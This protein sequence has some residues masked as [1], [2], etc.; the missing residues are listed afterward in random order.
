M[1][2]REL[3]SVLEKFAAPELQEDYD[4]AGLITG[5]ATWE[6]TG[7]LCTLDVTEDVI[8]E[9]KEKNCNLVVAHH[10]IIFKGLKRITGKN[11]VEQVVIAAIKNDTFTR[12]I[13]TST[14]FFWA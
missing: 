13:P 14:I 2:I 9:A 10:P 8:R 12:H 4:N 3:I 6:C 5:N 11:Y 7:A 1:N